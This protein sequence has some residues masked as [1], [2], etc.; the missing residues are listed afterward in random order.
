MSFPFLRARWEEL[1]LVN[2][3]LS[4]PTVAAALPSALEPDLLEGEAMVSLVA[5]DFNRIRVLGLPWP[6][7]TSFPEV[8][9]RVYVR[10]KSTGHR[11]V[12]FIREFIPRRLPSL[13]A[14]F[15][16]NEPYSWC[17]IQRES[18]YREPTTQLQSTSWNWKGRR[19]KLA[20]SLSERV[21][22]PAPDSPE[23]WFKEQN[24]GF[25]ASRSG[26]LIGYRVKHPRWMVR[27]VRPESLQLEIDWDGL[28]GPYW[29]RQLRKRKPVSV[30]HAIGSE[31]SV[32]LPEYRCQENRH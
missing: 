5:F 21:Y 20:L 29:G 24:W 23:E 10:E 25:G 15:G 26:E 22:L 3:P 4:P 14:R 32:S 31:I 9:L 1:T 18:A 8:N 13:I 30:V 6:G 27:E 2:F 16:Y 12:F 17:E 7:Y 28:Y 11:G 19:S